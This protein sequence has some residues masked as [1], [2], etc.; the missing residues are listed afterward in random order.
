MIIARR[1]IPAMR[2]G[3]C[4]F[5][6]PF[7]APQLKV[8]QEALALL[9]FGLFSTFVLGVRIRTGPPPAAMY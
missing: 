1:Q 6:G 2:L 3:S 5:G 7:S 9:A 4:D 8:I